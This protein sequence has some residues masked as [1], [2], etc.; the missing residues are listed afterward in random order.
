MI[1]LEQLMKVRGACPNY[2]SCPQH[3]PV[4]AC[5]ALLRE[6]GIEPT[7]DGASFLGDV[8]ENFALQIAGRMGGARATRSAVEQSLRSLVQ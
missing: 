5:A 3:I 6:A 4:D 8:V 1:D 7:A 2:N